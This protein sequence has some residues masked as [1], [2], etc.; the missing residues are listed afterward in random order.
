MYHR[1]P[2]NNI[3]KLLGKRGVLFEYFFVIF[4]SCIFTF[5]IFRSLHPTIPMAYW[6]DAVG[7]L[8]I[9]K[10]MLETGS[11]LPWSFITSYGTPSVQV[12]WII[13]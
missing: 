7:N 2:N 11:P 1:V 8:A 3:A 10:V 4:L 9:F 6:G 13:P 12:S 5:Y